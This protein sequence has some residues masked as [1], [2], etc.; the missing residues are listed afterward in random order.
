MD[1]DNNKKQNNFLESWWY[2]WDSAWNSQSWWRKQVVLWKM[3][4]EFLQITCAHL[5]C[6]YTE[7][8]IVRDEKGFYMRSE[9]GDEARV[10]EN[11]HYDREEITYST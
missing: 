9:K 5:I 1:I 10:K 4:W 3:K 7:H 8:K 11:K 2:I 6:C